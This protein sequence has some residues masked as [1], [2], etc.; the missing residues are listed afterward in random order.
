MRNLEVA[1]IV[2]QVALIDR[3]S[4]EYF[5]RPL[6]NIVFMGMGEPMMNYKN[7]VE[8]IHK[9]TNLTVWECRQEELPF[10]HPEF[11]R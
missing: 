1:E 9:I 11:R 3:Q 6:T 5:D 4:K 8:A 2:D 7:V 10:Q